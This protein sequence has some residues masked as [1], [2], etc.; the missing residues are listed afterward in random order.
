MILYKF[1]SFTYFPATGELRVAGGETVV[2]RHKVSG[3]LT[4]LIDNRARLVAKQEL[5]EALWQHGE[6]REN[7]LTQSIKELRKALG[8][9][10]QS[11]QF[12]KTFPQRGYQW[13]APVSEESLIKEPDA[14]PLPEAAAPEG[15]PAQVLGKWHRRLR[16]GPGSLA[17]V[18]LGALFVAGGGAIWTGLAWLGSSHSGASAES[19]ARSH[20]QPSLLVFPFTNETGD[21]TKE[22]LELGFADMLAN[23][24]QASSLLRVMPPAMT[25][26]LLLSEELEWPVLPVHIRGLLNE[27]QEDYALL[28]S[29]RTHNG[30]QVLDFQ[31]LYRDG[32]ANQ[33]S[34]IYPSLPD[35]TGAVAQQVVLLLQA[36]HQGQ[37]AVVDAKDNFAE[38]LAGQA[39]AEGMNALHLSGPLRA[40]EFFQAAYLIDK[41]NPWVVAYLAQANVLLG[42]WEEG[43]KQLNQLGKTYGGV[44]Q[45]LD[46]FRLYWQA[47]LAHRQGDKE[48]ARQH[49][50]ALFPLVDE[51]S[52]MKLAADAYR[53][54]AQLAWSDRRWREHGH[55]LSKAHSLMPRNGDLHI[56]ADKLYYLGSP[57]SDGLEKD[58]QQDLIM[59]QERLQKALNLYTQLGSKPMLAATHFALAQN[60]RIELDYRTS[61]LQKAIALYRST[62]QKHELVD[63]LS[64]ASFFHLQLREG[65]TAADYAEQAQHVVNELGHHRSQ[66][67]LNFLRAFAMLDQGL[68]QRHRGLH[69]PDKQKLRAA[70]KLF[71]ETIASTDSPGD[72]A[73]ALV[74][75]A[76]AHSS[77]GDYQKALTGLEQA[78]RFSQEVSMPVTEAHAIYSAMRIHLERGDYEKVVALGGEPTS[79]RQQLIFLARAHYEL[80]N[81][82]DA[83]ATQ[84]ELKSR[85]PNQWAMADEER[86]QVYQR[87]SETG[88]AVHLQEEIPVHAV[89]CESEW[90]M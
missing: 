50:E 51:Q 13:I 11:P 22:W 40:H 48:Q 89:Y 73:T 55:W 38:G 60:Y 57:I 90:A 9:R 68:D 24:I 17:A 61:S 16:R 79:T 21:P 31:L 15:K 28:G 49:L 35:S 7:S 75:Q 37:L 39:L 3:L 44:S 69:G 67:H 30:M 46:A 29:V 81:F 41:Q 77:L 72:L 66:S 85:Y 63:V 42:R 8:D 64:Y 23:H 56:E 74:L 84:A 52:S 70:V 19:S 20:A 82:A 78:R 32:R 1:A 12:V 47:E 54:R 26:G 4:Y 18:V 80:G 43:A 53:L 45:Q 76:W 2:L 10:A 33:G 86:Y 6:Y 71:E 5:L 59:S 27:R 88:D 62:G 65:K 87:A 25:N 14:D 58:P 36:D 83:V 34:I